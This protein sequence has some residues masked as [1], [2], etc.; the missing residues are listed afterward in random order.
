M[1]MAELGNVAERMT[2]DL[3]AGKGVAAAGAL[4]MLTDELMGLPSL[5]WSK[6]GAEYKDLSDAE[7]EELKAA[8]AAKLD[9][10]N[11]KV[12]GKIEAALHLAVDLEKLVQGVIA[13]V[14]KG[15]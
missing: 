9:L 13:L 5:E 4:L 3:K 8:L 14:K 7:R 11:D 1:L 10:E 12:E 6:L 15:E 2:L